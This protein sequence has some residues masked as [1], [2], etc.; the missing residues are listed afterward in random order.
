[1]KNIAKKLINT[2]GFTLARK[3]KTPPNF[4]DGFLALYEK[5]R[6]F[7]MTSIERMH[8]LYQSVR[9][10]VANRIPGVLVECGVWK[11]GSC[12]LIA[13]TLLQL[14]VTDR[15]ILLYD[16]F[17]GMSEPTDLD[18]TAAGSHAWD[19]WEVTKQGS[20]WCSA[21]LDEVKANMRSTGLPETQIQYIQGKVEETLPGSLAEAIAILRLDTDW[22]ESTKAEMEIL[23]PRLS[24]HGILILDDYGHWEGTKAAVD[25]YFRRT[26]EAPFL[27]RVDHAG[28]IAVK[29]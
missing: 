17:E 27:Q 10:V 3:P 1:M 5:C 16:T 24:R 8:A 11:G 9:Y 28:R 19:R 6:P 12:M 21:G 26:G 2:L 14:G 23:Y 13:H 20:E 25:E 15:R 18:R 22:Y 4:D 29:I 7:T